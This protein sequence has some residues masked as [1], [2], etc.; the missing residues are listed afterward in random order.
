M[1]AQLEA[2]DAL[3]EARRLD[4]TLQRLSTLGAQLFGDR[5]RV[6]GADWPGLA[7][8][9]GWLSDLH[10]DAR[11][12]RLPASAI[13]YLA[14]H[15]TGGGLGAEAARGPF[16]ALAALWPRL[17]ECLAWGPDTAHALTAMPFEAQRARLDAWAAH[18]E[19]LSAMVRLNH[20]LER[21]RQEG[22]EALVPLVGTWAGAGAHLLD[23]FRTTWCEF[24]LEAAYR[25]RPALLHFDGDG[26]L[27]AI[28]RFR[29]LDRLTFAYHR[30]RLAS[31]HWE[32]LPR[33]D[34]GGQLG[35]LTKEFEKKTRHLP[36]R[37]LME[38]AG[39]P[40]QAI[41][42]VFMMSPL[43]IAGFLPPGSVNFDLVIFDEASQVKPVDAFGALLRGKR[44]VVVGDK[45]QMPP[46]N[47]FDSVGAIDEDDETETGDIES[48]LG[49]F[50]AQ[51]APQRMLRWHYRS[52]HESLIAVSNREFYESRLVVFPSPDGARE[53]TGL[54]YHH[55][56]HTA[57]DRGGSRANAGEAQGVAEAVM[58]HARTRPH[59]TLGVA[60]FSTAQQSAIQEQL[61]VLRRADPACE[62]FFSTAVAE[63]FF[64]K[65]LETIQG[66]ERDVIYI[67]V[68]YGRSQD[69]YLSMNFGPL[70]RDGGERRLNVLITRARRRCEVFTNLAPEDID[71]HATQA[72]GVR[73]LKLFLTYAAT[74]R[75][76]VATPTG[77][78]PD[79][80]FEAMVIAELRA[81][82]HQVEPQVGS[83][84]FFIDLAVVDPDRPG[85]YLLGVE[86]DGATY[87]SARSAR[88]RDRLR[89]Q[90]LAEIVWRI[91][92]IWSTDWFKHPERELKRLVAAIEEARSAGV[93][94]MPPAPAVEAPVLE[95][96]ATALA[97]PSA[98]AVPVYVQAAIAV[99]LGDLE[100][101]Q[102]PPATIAQWVAQ[103]VEAE[104]PVHVA[105]VARRLMSAAGVKRTGTRIQSA[106]DAGVAAALRGLPLER[107]GDFLWKQ[108]E[109]LMGYRDRGS[110]PAASRK[111]ELIAPEE[112]ALAVE[113]AVR[114]SFGLEPAQL[115]ASVGRLL[116]FG[117][118]NDEARAQLEAIVGTMVA[119][120]RLELR[121]G[122][123][124]L[125]ERAGGAPLAGP[126]S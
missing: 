45:R 12:G 35:V 46:T 2:I 79:S 99:Q 86:C 101:A 93:D 119:A 44:V 59:L 31:A 67:S 38:K 97:P 71:L 39:V 122:H 100:F 8:V 98:P 62:P 41:K 11:S 88:D 125:G 22:L 26:H 76:D 57:Y 61:E 69:G 34:A 14:A 114:D 90:V 85:R 48:I 63:P 64:V 15:P 126:A 73:A 94:A 102:V 116:G 55:L 28:G 92:R 112:V 118:M 78:A 20:F 19:A 75:L 109:P 56:S 30:A 51:G 106:F 1:D 110:L 66:D 47:F 80:P 123:L 23:A 83:A 32:A 81:L 17:V 18:P 113:A 42:P 43:S 115:P 84:G 27:H 36:I 107:R 13:G 95:R 60:A 52:R 37:R 49:L 82:G 70:N 54:A 24:L 21:C 103:V 120:R 89:Q 40:I 7:A 87:H 104:G 29:E 65:N 74:G 9:A 96:E 33:T 10:A 105:E 3:L 16:E 50:E 121:G 4:E 111:I 72:R 91:H 108:G 124:V 5:W 68:G 117:R 58:H 53:E 6:A 77:K 25:D